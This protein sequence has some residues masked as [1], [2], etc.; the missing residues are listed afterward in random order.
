MNGGLS[1]YK[2]GPRLCERAATRMPAVRFTDAMLAEFK[3]VMLTR[4]DFKF[5]ASD[6]QAIMAETGLDKEQVQQRAR[7]FR[8]RYKTEQ[9]RKAF[10]TTEVSD[11]VN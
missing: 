5:T 10:L 8:R 7:D 2:R 3:R 4:P 1:L 11:K 6:V 9:E